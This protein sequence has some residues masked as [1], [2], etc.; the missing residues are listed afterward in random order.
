M[1]DM[2]IW[3][4]TGRLGK[5]PEIKKTPSGKEVCSVTM[6]CAFDKETTWVNLVFWD[7]LAGPVGQYCKTGSF[8]R[9]SGRLQIRSYETDGQTKYVTEIVVNDMQMLGARDDGAPAQRQAPK[10][11]GQRSPVVEDDMDVPF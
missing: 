6:A 5:M 9:V 1:R 10:V 4:G 2:N 11:Q 3:H 7:K 8:V